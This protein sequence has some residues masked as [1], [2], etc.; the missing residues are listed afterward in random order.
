M[1]FETFIRQN[2]RVSDATV[3]RYV[4]VARSF[5]GWLGT[6]PIDADAMQDGERWLKGRYGQNSLASN[7]VTAVNLWLRWKGHPDLRIRRPPKAYNPR[8]RTIADKDYRDLL[9]R[10]ADPM[11]RLAVSLSHDAGWSPSDIAQIRKADIQLGDVTVVRK[12][13]QKTRV[14]AEAVLLKETAADLQAYLEAHPG[15]DYLFPGD[16]RKGKPHDDLRPLPRQPSGTSGELVG[17]GDGPPGEGPQSRRRTARL[18]VIHVCRALRSFMERTSVRT[19]P[20]TLRGSS[21]MPGDPEHVLL[22]VRT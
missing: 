18:R 17:G 8:P 2:A 7:V 20:R 12:V 9:A 13:R 21:R 16:R 15:M 3:K 10:I 19:G 1:K 5:A 6:R 4:D 14:T 11:E 22:A